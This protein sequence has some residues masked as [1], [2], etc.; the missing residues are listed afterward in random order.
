SQ[1]EVVRAELAGCSDESGTVV[2]HDAAGRMRWWTWAGGRANA[3]LA[4]ALRSVLEPPGQ[5]ENLSLRVRDGVRFQDFRAAV[6]DGVDDVVPPPAIRAAAARSLKFS[7]ALPH[8]LV[9]RVLGER[10][11]DAAGAG[12]LLRQGV[13]H[14]SSR[15]RSRM[16]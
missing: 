5:I 12:A 14:L 8:D 13:S 16:L 2:V 10:I 15:P 1:L 4:A 6:R 3:S 11:G 7:D 9:G